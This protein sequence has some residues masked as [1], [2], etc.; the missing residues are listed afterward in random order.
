M[1]VDPIEPGHDIHGVASASAFMDAPQLG[2]QLAILR[3][4]VGRFL[5][6]LVH[7]RVVVGSVGI[8]PHGQA[9]PLVV[10]QLD[11]F[12]MWSFG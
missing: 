9:Q 10:A 6:P 5:R 12:R 3:Q 1:D 4:V 11:A 2:E 7:E 8:H